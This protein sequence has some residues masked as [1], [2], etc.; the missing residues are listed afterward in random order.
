[1][2]GFEF[3]N[4]KV[5]YNSDFVFSTN[6][7]SFCLCLHVLI[8][9]RWGFPSE[10]CVNQLFSVGMKKI[11]AALLSLPLPVPFPRFLCGSAGIVCSLVSY[12][13]QGGRAGDAPWFGHGAPHPAAPA[14]TP[15]AVLPSVSHLLL[16][17]TT[18]PTH[19]G[20]GYKRRNR[21]IFVKNYI[22]Y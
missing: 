8:V 9:F 11:N 12:G 22:M 13:P 4:C 17:A 10:Y 3:C 7:G 16:T 1:M 14:F 20:K 21:L 19:T 6:T 15:H 5:N 18:A 2:F